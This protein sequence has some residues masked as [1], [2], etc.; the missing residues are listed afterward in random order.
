MRFVLPLAFCLMAGCAVS[1]NLPQE[2]IDQIPPGANRIDLY[3]DLPVDELNEQIKQFLT[4]RGFPIREED[5]INRRV[6]TAARDIGQRTSLYIVYRTSPYESGSKL[7]AIGVWSSDV[8]EF[9]IPE[10]DQRVAAEDMDAY[11]VTWTG[12]GRSSYAFSQMVLLF[13]EFPAREIR[14]V[15]Q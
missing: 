9:N 11:Q 10:P 15:K 6:E 5:T 2:K 4:E 8:E 1:V 12:A 7:E 3:S 13:D 14:Y